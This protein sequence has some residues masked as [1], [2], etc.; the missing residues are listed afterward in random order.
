MH[1]G[2][3]TVLRD[4]EEGSCYVIIFLQRIFQS[5]LRF[6]V[7]SSSAPRCSRRSGLGPVRAG[8]WSNI[9]FCLTLLDSFSLT[10]ILPPRCLFPSRCL[11]ITAVE[12]A[13]I[14]AV[15]V[16]DYQAAPR[17]IYFCQ[18]CCAGRC[19]FLS[20]SVDQSHQSQKQGHDGRGFN[21]SAVKS[22]NLGC[23]SNQLQLWPP[24]ELNDL[25]SPVRW[26][27]SALIFHNRL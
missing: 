24:Q 11:R 20:A 18:H 6:E 3:H 14:S 12:P 25:P 8:T 1:L 9:T 22:S 15:G 26:L 23:Y 10:S 4:T 27:K 16:I 7:R 2:I 19:S 5:M 17:L 21:P 13:L